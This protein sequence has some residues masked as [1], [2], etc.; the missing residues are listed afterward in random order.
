[1]QP[2]RDIA[3]AKE[4]QF[5]FIEAEATD[6]NPKDNSVTV[7]TVTTG[8]TIT[9]EYDKL[10]MAIGSVSNASKTKGADQNSL[11]LRDVCD[12]KKIR[13]KIVDILETASLP[14]TSEEERAR[15]LHFV[16]VGG[17]PYA[18]EFAHDVH[19]Y[20][21]QNSSQFSVDLS[22]FIKVSLVD[23]KDHINNFYDK[24]IS[25]V[26]DFSRNPFCSLPLITT[27]SLCSPCVRD[28]CVAA[29]KSSPRTHQS[30]LR[31]PQRALHF[32]F[33]MKMPI[34]SLRNK[35]LAA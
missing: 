25:K 19:E 7:K 2:F 18:V 33:G 21:V 11:K 17:S 10:I 23:S 30:S 15:L 29:F 22:K 6:I 5:T 4:K 14:T 31:F 12:A 28:S 20:L 27:L 34:D 3:G 8:E 35:S 26:R 1:V 24:S 13:S 9:L 32:P 16:V